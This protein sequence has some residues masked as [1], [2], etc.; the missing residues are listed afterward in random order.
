MTHKKP[1]SKQM[2][3][4][5]SSAFTAG[6]VAEQQAEGQKQRWEIKQIARQA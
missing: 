3:R 4:S 1:V 6:T 2:A 5:H